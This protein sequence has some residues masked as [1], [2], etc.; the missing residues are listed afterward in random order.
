MAQQVDIGVICLN[1]WMPNYEEEKSRIA[2]FK[3]AV[4]YHPPKDG[5]SD[6]WEYGYAPVG[7]EVF[8][9]GF[10]PR[11]A[12]PG[13]LAIWKRGSVAS[14]PLVNIAGQMPI[15]FV[16]SATRH[17]MSGSPVLHFGKAL[18]NSRGLPAP[19]PQAFVEPWLVGVYAGRRGS[20]PEEQEMS[21]GRV[22]HRRHLLSSCSR[23][24]AYPDE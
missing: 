3:A 13:T 11:L 5:K 4:L 8:I 14:E 2:S 20:S 15:F 9:L 16:D 17:G 1:D 21:L 7:A 24:H 22:W 18:I 12:L 19:A 23:R 10:P 6:Y